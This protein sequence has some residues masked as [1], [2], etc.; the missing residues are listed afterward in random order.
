MGHIL[1]WKKAYG[2]ISYQCGN[3]KEYWDIL[4]LDAVQFDRW[5]PI[6]QKNLLPPFNLAG[7]IET[8]ITSTETTRS[9]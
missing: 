7:Y 1:N 4:S 9:L 8:S 2:R 5:M 6:F 3:N